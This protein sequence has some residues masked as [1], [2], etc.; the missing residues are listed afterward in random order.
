M[1]TVR[2][3][4]TAS[5]LPDGRVLVAGGHDGSGP[6]DSADLYDPSTGLFTPAGSMTDSRA[7][8]TAT[9][10]TDGRVLVVGGY[11]QDSA[12]L[13]TAELYQP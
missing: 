10:L 9:V 1:S 3:Y 7:R 12:S 2:Y 4:P 5:T 8:H 6:L 11:V 13:D